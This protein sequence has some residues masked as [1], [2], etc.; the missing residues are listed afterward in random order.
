LY[1]GITPYIRPQRT[2]NRFLWNN[3]SS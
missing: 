3:I 2:A 1:S